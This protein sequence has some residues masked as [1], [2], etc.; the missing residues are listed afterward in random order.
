V[1]TSLFERALRLERSGHR[2]MAMPF[3]VGA[4]RESPDDPDVWVAAGKAALK[5]ERPDAAA[6][7]LEQ[8]VRRHPDSRRAWSKLMIARLRMGEIEP[9]RRL[10]QRVLELEP[11]NVQAM[12]MLGYTAPMVGRAEE[13]RAW[14]DR[15]FHA[16]RL[17][18]R[19]R[20]DTFEA[21]LICGDYRAGWG[22]FHPDSDH[23][24]PERWVKPIEPYW[25]GERDPDATVCLHSFGGIGDLF[26]LA[27]FFPEIAARVGTLLIACPDVAAPLI[28]AVPGVAALVRRPDEAPDGTMFLSG[29]QI[30]AVM[31]T[32]LESVPLRFPY[33]HPTGAAPED[34]DSPRRRV[35]LAWAGNPALWTDPDR[36]VPHVELLRPLVATS[37]IEWV[38][39]Q[40][41]PRE[42][43][44]AELEIEYRPILRDFGDT[45]DVLQQLDLVVTVDTAV[46]N[47]SLA[48]GR[49]TW[50]MPPTFVDYRWGPGPGPSP[51]YPEARL[52][53][54]RSSDDWPRVI[55]ELVAAL[56][57]RYSAQSPATHH[58]G[59]SV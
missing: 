16:E 10:C 22:V 9:A 3:F 5:L 38:S 1:A 18:G 6:E 21:R 47:L 55:R 45:A 51:W 17:S 2:A 25:R 50:V 41:G 14:F 48:M 31:E 43:W 29:L 49:P 54:R 36:S 59:L 53:R 8:A 13:A 7:L 39:L 52:F 33:L 12:A 4:T 34:G 11:A 15:A 37:G 30:P 44:A 28:R 24:K 35:G 40:V 27:R 23:R 20:L 57:E 46:A 56:G 26:L 42:E 32:T 19:R 58:A